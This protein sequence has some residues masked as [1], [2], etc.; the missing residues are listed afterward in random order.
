MSGPKAFSVHYQHPNGR[1]HSEAP[2][3]LDQAIADLALMSA[4][5]PEVRI[6]VQAIPPSEVP[7]DIEGADLNFESIER[8][9]T[10]PE[11]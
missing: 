11:M 7:E 5:H 8:K 2:R 1:T 10:A 4:L 6:W 9:I 3:S